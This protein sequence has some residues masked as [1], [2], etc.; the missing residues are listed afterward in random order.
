MTAIRM[1]PRWLTVAGLL[2]VVLLAS[3]AH[4]ENPE[5][6]QNPR[7]RSRRAVE[8]ERLRFKLHERVEYPLR[9]RQLRSDITL[10]E[11]EVAS[12]RRRIK[13]VDG[14][15]GSAA[16][17]TMREDLRLDLLA[18]ELMV[19]DAKH[20]L[21]LLQNHHQDERRLRQLLMQDAQQPAR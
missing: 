6:P 13:E 12:L 14:F 16:L 5:N 10:M 21:A 7:L 2:S 4:G 15:Y 1:N 17:F 18:A 8:I 19:N 20:E 9:Q 3:L 11:A